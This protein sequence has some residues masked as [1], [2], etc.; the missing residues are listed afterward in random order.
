[1]KR[2]LICGAGIA[3]AHLIACC[4]SDSS[5]QVDVIEKQKGERK[6]GYM[7]AFLEMA[8]KLQKK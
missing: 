6:S 8:G 3:G 5:W 2:V 1:M 4:L 7:I